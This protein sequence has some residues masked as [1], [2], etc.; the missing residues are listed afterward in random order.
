MSSRPFHCWSSFKTRQPGTVA[1]PCV[2]MALF[3]GKCLGLAEGL[4]SCTQWEF[5]A[6]KRGKHGSLFVGFFWRGWWEGGEAEG[7][8]SQQAYN[9]R[10]GALPPGDTGWTFD[11]QSLVKPSLGEPGASAMLTVCSPVW[12]GCGPCK[13]GIE[14]SPEENSLDIDS[15]HCNALG[16]LWVSQPPF[17][18]PQ[19]PGRLIC[20]PRKERS[21]CSL[22]L[23]L[24][25]WS[26]SMP[27][28]THLCTPPSAG[29]GPA[30]PSEAFV[31]SGFS[32]VSKHQ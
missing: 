10:T 20:V 28:G 19:H 4:T 15:G 27:K 5:C 12:L 3:Q 13:P 32:P 23:V 2:P 29:T 16:H 8:L 7:L 31:H 30:V 14:Y 1:T 17:Y 25:I 24:S 21:H 6:L 18:C 22:A 26:R 9:S 11:P